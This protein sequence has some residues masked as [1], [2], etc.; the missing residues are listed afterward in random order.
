MASGVCARWEDSHEDSL[1]MEKVHKNPP[2]GTY[3]QYTGPASGKS[4]SYLEH[5]RPMQ[6]SLGRRL[7]D[8]RQLQRPSLV[9]TICKQMF[10]QFRAPKSV[11]ALAKFEEGQYLWTSYT[12][13]SSPSGVAFPAMRRGV[14]ATQVKCSQA[15]ASAHLQRCGG[16]P[17]SQ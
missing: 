6:A 9:V 16:T 5:I 3:I 8:E 12:R 14:G 7:L 11:G 4:W 2:S 15:P 10:T 17:D 13:R 1:D